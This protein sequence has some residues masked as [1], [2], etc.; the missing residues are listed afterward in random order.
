MRIGL[1]TLAALITL[2]AGA[3]SAQPMDTDPG[4]YGLEKTET[5]FIRLDR[6]TGAVSF[7]RE[8]RA[9]LTCRMAADERAAYDQDLDMLAKRVDALEAQI[10][11]KAPNGPA[12]S[13][14]EIEQ[15]LSIMERFMRRFK[16]LVD[17]F[18][19]ED[20]ERARP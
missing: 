19:Q 5:G 18:R 7:C 13:E 4:R 8:E 17:E 3:T 11:R 15:S 9:E 20:A 6:Q 1:F 14:A 10:A 12:A 16:A 2:G